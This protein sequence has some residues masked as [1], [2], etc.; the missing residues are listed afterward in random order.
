M[1]HHHTAEFIH[2]FFSKTFASAKATLLMVVDARDSK[3]NTRY[4]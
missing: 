2:S 3:K 1:K 4:Y